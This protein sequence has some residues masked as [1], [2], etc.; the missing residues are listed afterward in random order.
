MLISAVF[1]EDV[2]GAELPFKPLRKSAMKDSGD[3]QLIVSADGVNY[4]FGLSP[5]DAERKVLIIRADGGP[6]SYHAIPESRIFTPDDFILPQARTAE[7]YNEFLARWRDQNYSLWNRT[8]QEQNNEDAVIAYGG[9]ALARGTFK[10][11]VAA[12]PPAFL[13]GTGRTYE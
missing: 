11:A 4:G 2:S 5:M 1:P 9:E 6:V 12:V 8:I 13:R 7:A 10:A 3:G